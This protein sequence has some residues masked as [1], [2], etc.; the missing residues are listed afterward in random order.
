MPGQ[1]LNHMPEVDFLCRGEGEEV[2]FGL[3]RALTGGSDF[4]GVPGLCFIRN[5]QPVETGLAHGAKDL[6]TY[7]SPY[8][9]DLIDLRHKE[10]AILL[11][12]RGCA[13]DCAFC[14]TPRASGRKVRFFSI[15]RVIEEM[16]HLRSRGINAFWFADTNFSVSRNRLVAFLEAVVREVPGVTFWCQTRYDLMNSEL[17]ALLKRAGAENI[18]YG[19]ESAN[20]SVLER[21]RKPIDLQRLSEVVRMTQDAGIRVELFSMFGLPGETFHQALNTLA[22]VKKNNVSVDGNSISQQ[23]HLFFG[24]PMAETPEE[25]GIRPFKRTRPAYLSVCREFVTD[26]MSAQEIR[27]I[28][29]IWRLNRDDFGEDVR[30]ERNLFHRA[31]FIAKDRE[32]LADRPEAH[33]LLARIY[34]ALE[35]YPAAV[36]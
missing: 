3:A 22:F 10:R 24:T 9:T 32:T 15:E 31:A 7:A 14:Y 36:H 25:Y 28:S 26:A 1:A 20:P 35:Q 4:S 6:D 23:A 2:M 5:G 16:Q 17:L 27:R 29:L 33:C 18:A 12:S 21:I 34:L 13:Y 30:M 19:L 8:L 11:T